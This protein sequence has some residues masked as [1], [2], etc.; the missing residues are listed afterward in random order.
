MK[1]FWKGFTKNASSI[2]FKKHILVLFYSPDDE[3]SSLMKSLMVK[4][5]SKFPSVKVKYVNIKKDESKKAHH[6]VKILPTVLLLKDGREVDRLESGN[7]SAT[8]LEQLYRKA[9]T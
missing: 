5:N 6:R 1:P 7:S 2:Q 9:T 4:L 8:F 3:S